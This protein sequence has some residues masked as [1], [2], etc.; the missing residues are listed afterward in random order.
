MGLI[1]GVA[2]FLVL[3]ERIIIHSEGTGDATSVTPIEHSP[4][5]DIKG[6][7]KLLPKDIIEEIL[8]KT[9]I[10]S[11][12][13]VVQTRM[14]HPDD[15]RMNRILQNYIFIIAQEIVND[16]DDD[17]DINEFSAYGDLYVRFHKHQKLMS[18][19]DRFGHQV[20]KI[21]IYYP[22]KRFIHFIEVIRYIVKICAE[23]LEELRIESRDD[24]G[25]WKGIS[26]EK[27]EIIFPNVKKFEFFGESNRN[28]LKLNLI[29]PK[30]ES[31]NLSGSI[32]D[33]YCLE[34]VTGLQEL[35]LNYYYCIA[36][37]IIAKDELQLN[38]IFKNNKNMTKVSLAGPIRRETMHSIAK[39]L[40]KLETLEVELPGDEFLLRANDS[41][42]LYELP[43]VTHFLISSIHAYVKLENPNISFHMPNL[44]RLT[45]NLIDVDDKAIE[46]FQQ[47]KKLEILEFFVR[48]FNVVET[49]ENV[50]HIKEF[51]TEFYEE[52]G[53]ESVE[54]YFFNGIKSKL[55]TL[56]FINF[57]E[58]LY[59]KYENSIKLI[60]DHLK[61]TNQP[62]W[63]ISMGEHIEMNEKFL[64]YRREVNMKK[65]LMF[66]RNL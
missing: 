57:D 12:R 4:D 61:K 14:I 5:I 29:F 10:S 9:D 30:L 55:H 51:T 41:V 22:L 19:F 64:T 1:Y 66:R 27:N 43:L 24:R 15:I 31:L 42:A 60:N 11:I 26:N 28:E 18:F 32:T 3:F 17:D 36:N 37:D 33:V 46:F 21:I 44:K 50:V 40:T 23:N 35:T 63:T 59:P 52:T 39:Y 47:F 54:S 20:K 38:D 48:D 13:N 16:D 49:I 25:L 6:D 45:V 65:Y 2:V 58:E 8:I 56:K 34:N 53:F 7:L 62:T